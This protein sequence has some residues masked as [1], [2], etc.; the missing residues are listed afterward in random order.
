M[1]QSYQNY[2]SVGG[3]IPES[4]LAFFGP[5]ESAALLLPLIVQLQLF[6]WF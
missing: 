2:S 1:G 3:S 5:P 6:E 4:P